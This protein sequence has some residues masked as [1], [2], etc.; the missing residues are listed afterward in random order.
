[1]VDSIGAKRQNESEK[2]V[3]TSSDMTR[4]MVCGGLAGM[5]AKVSDKMGKHSMSDGY[6]LSNVFV[7][8]Y[9]LIDCYQSVRTNQNAFP[10]R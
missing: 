4:R 5:V 10:N 7:F 1:M 3:I 8:L 6:L 9:V 2:K